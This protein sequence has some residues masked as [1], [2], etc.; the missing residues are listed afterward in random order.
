MKPSYRSGR[1]ESMQLSLLLLGCSVEVVT[2]IDRTIGRYSFPRVR[3]KTSI[4]FF[5]NVPNRFT[6]QVRPVAFRLGKVV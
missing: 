2:K 4:D 3:R 5:N 6:G 1:Y